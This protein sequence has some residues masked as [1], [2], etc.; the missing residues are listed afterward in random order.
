MC[1]N[2]FVRKMTALSTFFFLSCLLFP[3]HPLDAQ[4]AEFPQEN[5]WFEATPP[6][7][8]CGDASSDITLEVHIVGRDDVRRLWLTNLMFPDDPEAARELF[9]DGTNGDET[10][11][12]NVFSLTT[13]AQNIPCDLGRLSE[14]GGFS[15]WNGFIRVQLLDGAIKSNYYPF[16]VGVAHPDYRDAFEVEDLGAGLSAT[17]YAFFIEDTGYEIVNDYPVAELRCGQSNF[18]AFQ[19]FYSVMPDDFDF[20]LVT[21]GMQL[22]RTGDLAENTPYE[23]NVSNNV[24]HIGM[25]IFDNTA[26]F[27]SGGRLRSVIYHSFGDLA[28]MDHELGHAWAATIGSSLDLLDS[29]YTDSNLTGHWDEMADVEGQMGSYYFTATGEVGHFSYQASDGLDFWKL[30]PNTE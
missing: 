13:S 21:P 29:E 16:A 2:S 6:V 1:T 4:Y 26:L 10:G 27:G 8:W 17:R 9:D 3:A 14:Y 12:D 19:R 18:V 15:K 28:I 22:F 7:I 30:T 25:N 20:A 11:G 24:Q 5:A 23:V